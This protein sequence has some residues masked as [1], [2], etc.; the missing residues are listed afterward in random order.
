MTYRP[1]REPEPPAERQTLTATSVLLG[2]AF[3]LLLVAI[4]VGGAAVVTASPGLLVATFVLA[5]GG[6]GVVLACGLLAGARTTVRAH[7]RRL[8]EREAF[9][10]PDEQI[11]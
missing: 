3:L 4:P 7:R 6:L 10:P 1:E 9:V 2:L 11:P 8:A 5:F